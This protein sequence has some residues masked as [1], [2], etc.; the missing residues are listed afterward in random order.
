HD[1]AE[2]AG[3][4]TFSFGE[5]EVD[6]YVMLFKK[7]FPPPDEELE[8]YRN[9]EEYDPETAHNTKTHDSIE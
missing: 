3:L 4:T 7:E 6:R 2:V 9:G 8:A 5:E 1:V